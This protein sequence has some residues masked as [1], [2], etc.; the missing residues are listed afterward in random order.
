LNQAC[1]DAEQN[2]LAFQ[3]CFAKQHVMQSASPA[4]LARA[5]HGDA[6]MLDGLPAWT[7]HFEYQEL[8]SGLLLVKLCIEV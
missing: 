6:F 3:L 1:H 5:A 7:A 8:L 2:L 4:A